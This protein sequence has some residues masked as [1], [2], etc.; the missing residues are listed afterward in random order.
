MSRPHLS[1][2]S[3]GVVLPDGRTLFRDLTF[4]VADER[5]G[6][7]GANGSGKSTLIQILAGTRAPSSGSVR[8]H[9]PIAVVDQLAASEVDEPLSGGEAMR[10]AL[11]VAMR[12]DPA[13]LL[14]DEP[15]NNLDAHH[16]HS[17]HALA[18]RWRR[19]LVVAS[20]DRALLEHVDRILELSSLGARW[21]SGGWSEYRAHVETER[22]AASR[23]VSSAKA[24]LDRT[25]RDLRAVQERKAK[26]D[27]R[28][29]R[30]RGT[31]SQ[32]AIV[33]N[34]GKARAEST[35]GKLGD[36]AE[37][38]RADAAARI[39]AARSRLATRTPLR[40]RMPSCALPA[41]TTVVS[42]ANVAVGPPG[43]EALLRG[44]AFDVVGPERVALVGPNGAGKTTLLRL[45]A[46]HTEPEAGTIHRGVPLSRVAYLD[47]HAE[48]L[49]TDGTVLDAVLA[50]HPKLT[51]H[52]ARETLAAFAF[53]A[54]AA[55]A[56]VTQL[57]GGERM[58]A[59][60]ACILTGPLPPQCLILDEPTNHLDVE[61]LETIESALDDYD[62][63]MI[64]ASHDEV[65]L[66]AL[67]I[68]RHIDVTQWRSAPQ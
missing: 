33:T 14:L 22:T 67:G 59:A 37:R 7:V 36:T 66:G 5:I 62:G 50:Q 6:I 45:L 9:S 13:V 53:R 18:A 47:Q 54:D 49:G 40:V 55:L 51:P 27:A 26:T 61:S 34:A 42:L 15:T 57:S 39:A 31:G 58:R 65:F 63:A 56:P 19:G 32:P 24:A 23:E 60:L 43:A 20:H 3:L 68:V 1:A 2:D 21:Y 46:N 25:E 29:R 11:A 64:V 28:G 17:V 30:E 38:A 41:G 12:S 10:R 4:A 52:D 48:I 35:A 16:R 44:V 8:R